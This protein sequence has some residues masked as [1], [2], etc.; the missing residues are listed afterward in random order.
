MAVTVKKTTKKRARAFWGALPHW[1]DNLDVH[2]DPVQWEFGKGSFGVVRRGLASHQWCE[3]LRQRN[4]STPWQ[5]RHFGAGADEVVALKVMP[6]KKD[7]RLEHATGEIMAMQEVGPHPH[8]LA[9][10]AAYTKGDVTAPTQLVLVLEA[11]AASLQDH[12]MRVGS[13]TFT[14]RGAVAWGAAHALAYC[15]SRGVLHAS[16]S[17]C[18]PP[19]TPAARPYSPLPRSRHCLPLSRSPSCTPAARQHTHAPHTPP[20]HT[21]PRLHTPGGP[22]PT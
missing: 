15:H 11:A 18:P 21:H 12:M 8:V 9:L 22:R 13:S 1:T 20:S 14:E 6:I 19:P 7:F 16:L 3:G 10:L 5:P 17:D 2:E 4:P